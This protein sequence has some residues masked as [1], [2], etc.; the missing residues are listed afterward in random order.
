[1]A[2]REDGCLPVKPVLFRTKPVFVNM[3]RVCFGSVVVCWKICVVNKLSWIII[4]NIK[5]ILKF[6]NF[7]FV[8]DGISSSKIAEL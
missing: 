7:L 8:K 2:L 4:I 6:C 3:R 1:M 5:N